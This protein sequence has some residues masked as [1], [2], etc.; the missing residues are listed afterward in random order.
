M[1]RGGFS[2][3]IKK[4]YSLVLTLMLLVTLIVSACSDKQTNGG[5][6]NSGKMNQSATESSNK[7]I[8]LT[9]MIAT[10]DDP[11]SKLEEQ[12]VAEHFADKYEI[13]FKQWDV[14]AAEQAIKT[15]ISAGEPIDLAMYWPNMMQ[16]FVTADMALDLTPYLEANNGEWKNTFVDGVLDVGTYDNKV[17]A[18]PFSAVYPL[19]EVNQDIL[20]QAGVTLS[21]SPS[22]DEFMT[23]LETIKQETGIIPFGLNSDWGPWTV[24]N[25]LISVWPDEENMNKFANGQISFE[26]PLALKAFDAAKELFDKE[27]VYPGQGALTTTLDQVNMAFKNKKIAIK[28]NVN[29]FAAQS[30]ADSG[31]ENIKIASWPSMNLPFVLGG[32]NGYMIPANAAHPEASIEVMKYLTSKEVLQKRVDGGSPV[33]IK[34]VESDDPNFD[35]YAKDVPRVVPKEIIALSTKLDDALAKMP[36]N[37]IFSGKASLD[38]IEQARLEAISDNN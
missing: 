15:T 34:G 16:S 36:A 27:L 26:D 29:I 4:K 3:I 37:Y 23:V 35:L 31:L 18:V 33:T 9:L 11:S 24:R 38:D 19:L 2:M 28:A 21:D 14:N 20:N 13:S 25:N 12:M 7:K 22:W 6:N 30:V 17:Y 1:K 32:A 5:A 8:K 10:A